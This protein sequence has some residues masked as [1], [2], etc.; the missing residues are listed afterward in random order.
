MKSAV[1]A[2]LVLFSHLGFGQ[3]FT[4]A[5]WQ[6]EAK[7]DKSL[8]P[9]YGGEKRTKEERK[10]DK[11]FIE[12]M[13]EASED[14][15]HASDQMIDLG[16]RYL[17][18]GDLKT[19]MS[20]FNQAWLLDES[21][22]DIFWGFGA[23]YMGLG[24]MD[25]AREQYEEGLGIDPTNDK[26]LTDYGTTYMADSYQLSESNASEA[27]SRLEMAIAKISEAHDINPANPNT[28][29]KLSICYFYLGDCEK[30]KR[31]L[32]ESEALDNANITE[33]Y[34]LELEE[35]CRPK[36]LDCSSVHTGKFKTVDDRLPGTIIDRNEEFQMEE[37]ERDGFK[38]KLRVTWIDDCTYQLVPVQGQEIVVD[39][40]NTPM[41]LTCRITEITDDGYIQISSSNI[42]PMKMKT[43]MVRIE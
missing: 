17:Y 42:D 11:A 32:S 3:G 28:S 29:Y 30:A 18:R 36:D 13:M 19:A 7:N 40:E 27:S 10:A 35:A 9:K 4:Y 24:E 33:S 21:N 25:L 8:L 34:K 15:R 14:K 26:I 6:E 1:F 22:S 43:K 38:I 31:F 23:V 41:I 37:S 20:R 39:E 5:D 2:L 12:E 16:F